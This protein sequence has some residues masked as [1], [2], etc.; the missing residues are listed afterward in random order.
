M[1]SV[2]NMEALLAQQLVNKAWH[3]ICDDPRMWSWLRGVGVLFSP[4]S[5]V[6]GSVT[7]T[8]FSATVNLDATANAA[9]NGLTHPLITQRQFRSAQGPVYNIAGYNNG[10]STLTLD[11]PYM[12]GSA[13]TQSYQIYQCYY[14]PTDSSGNVLSDFSK[15]RAILNPIDGYA[16]VGGSLD[17]TRAELDIV[18]PTRGS[19]DLAYCIA[20]YTVDSNG[21]PFFEMWPHPTAQRAYISLYQKR[22]LD[23]SATNDVPKTL[24]KQLV[25]QRAMYHAYDWAIVNSGRFPNL[26]GVNWPLLKAENLRAYERAL[27]DEKRKDDDLV[28]DQYLPELRNNL[29]YPPIDAKF[30]QN[31]DVSSYFS[32]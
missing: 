9:L 8:Q 4:Q 29:L 23:L 30:F 24:S 12:E 19:Q 26:K 13:V 21:I 1:G 17:V 14:Q 10:A 16:I 32:N 18:D 5:L 28:P 31:H 15:F 25:I 6:S 20:P 27:Q 2:P 3:E 11:R 22:G 7:V